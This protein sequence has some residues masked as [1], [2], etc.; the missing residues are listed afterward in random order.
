MPCYSDDSKVRNARAQYFL[1]AGFATDGG[2]GDRWVRLKVRGLTVFAFPNTAARVRSV[3][4]H[5]IH[6]IVTEYDTSWAGEA[7]IGAWELASGCGRHYPAWVLNLGA[8]TIG[9]LFW[10]R[11]V[12]AAF[13]RGRR[14]DNLYRSEFS[15]ELL[16]LTVGRLR[17]RLQLESETGDMNG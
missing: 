8:V 6:H 17:R 10:P 11:R 13:K 5:D 16:E 14:S 4:L 3:K 15:E 9:L 7:E 2:Y 12:I 1:Q